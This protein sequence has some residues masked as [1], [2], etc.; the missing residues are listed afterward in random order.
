M[1]VYRIT[2]EQWSKSLQGSGYLA[3]WNAKGRMV[4]Y[5]AGSRSLACLENLVHRSGE[6]QDKLYK[7]MLIE[8]PDKIKI[9]TIEPG[10]L[11]KGWEQVSNFA[12]CQLTAAEWLN[13][14]T[15]AILKVPSAI[16]K[17]EF[18][19]LINPQYADFKLIKLVGVEDFSFD[20]RF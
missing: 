18:N 9:D 2:T 19:Y 14:S 5:T 7:V 11:K 6:W 20:M 3:R 16:I 15:A 8:F 12:Y 10:T 17:N 13:N 1:I 4:I